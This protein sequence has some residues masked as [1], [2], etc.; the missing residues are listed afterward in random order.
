MTGAS[1]RAFGD[2]VG[3]S[4]DKPP[5]ITVD[6]DDSGDGFHSM[7]ANGDQE[8]RGHLHLFPATLSAM[9]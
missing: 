6:A 2:F 3:L 8:G 4:T 1:R 9:Y 5:S 7:E